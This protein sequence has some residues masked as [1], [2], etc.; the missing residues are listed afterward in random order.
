M[1]ATWDPS[2]PPGAVTALHVTASVAGTVHLAWSAPINTGSGIDHYEIDAFLQGGAGSDVGPAHSTSAVVSNLEPG[3]TYKLNVTTVAT[4]GQTS[5]PMSLTVHIPAVKPSAAAIKRI[6]GTKGGL[7]VYWSA[8]KST[9][10]APITS[11]KV[12]AACHGDVH[13]DHFGGDALNG[14]LGGLGGGTVCTVRVY[15]VNHAGESPSSAPVSGKT[16]S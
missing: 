15:A 10:G 2:I 7:H 6:V 16:L 1:A 14:T 8:P 4:D 3:G 9:G 13:T 12:T 11:Y 5:L